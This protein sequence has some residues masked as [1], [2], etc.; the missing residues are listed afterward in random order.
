MA[1]DR[2][3][4]RGVEGRKLGEW[5]YTHVWNSQ[6]IFKK[7][8]KEKKILKRANGDEG[9]LTGSPPLD[10]ERLMVAERKSSSSPGASSPIGLSRPKCMCIRA[11]LPG[12]SRL[13]CVCVCD[14]N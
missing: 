9:D 12:L 3:R 5:S 10:E 7:Y 6:S 4:C 11:A 2:Q 8:F 14:N 13:G 1:R